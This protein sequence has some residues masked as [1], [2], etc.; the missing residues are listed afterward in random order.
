MDT[1]RGA[2]EIAG[3]EKVVAS[4]TGVFQMTVELSDMRG[5]R[6]HSPAPV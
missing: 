6:Q 3:S 1:G 5:P 2:E 4:D